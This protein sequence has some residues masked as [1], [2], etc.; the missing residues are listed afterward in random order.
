MSLPNAIRCRLYVPGDGFGKRLM[1][2]L[3]SVLLMGLMLFQLA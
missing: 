3:V 1:K 2:E